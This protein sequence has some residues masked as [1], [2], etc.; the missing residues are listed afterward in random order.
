M[1]TNT[2]SMVLAAL[3]VAITAI[4]ARLSFPLGQVSV[5]LQFMC[6]ALAGVLLGPLWGTASQAVYLV[7]GLVGLPIFTLGGGPGYL[8]QPSMGFL[9]GFVLAAWVIGMLTRGPR[10]R[11][12]LRVALACVA[13]AAAM[14]A[15]G[16]PYMYLILNVYMEKALPV[17][18]VVTTGMLIYL[19]GDAIKVA[20]TAILTA[21]LPAKAFPQT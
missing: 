18:T 21:A 4:G 7:L 15:V 14:Y 9:F 1:R 11:K 8:L 12:P 2:R 6:S 16:V 17:W 10:A 13:G 20:A 3:F 5:S 19:P